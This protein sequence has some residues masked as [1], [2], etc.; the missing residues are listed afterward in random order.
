M[1]SKGGRLPMKLTA[2]PVYMESTTKQEGRHAMDGRRSFRSPC[3]LGMVKVGPE[4]VLAPLSGS[5]SRVALSTMRAALCEPS[6][7]RKCI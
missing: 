4:K 5:E 6:P 2:Y 1:A 3:C 7:R